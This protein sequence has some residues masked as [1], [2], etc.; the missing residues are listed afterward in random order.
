MHCIPTSSTYTDTCKAR[1]GQGGGG[2]GGWRLAE[3][4]GATRNDTK[5]T[6]R[7]K[8]QFRK[9]LVAPWDPKQIVESFSSPR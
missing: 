6:K 2:G 9:I 1:I 7:I 4:M 3:F 8:N 5:K